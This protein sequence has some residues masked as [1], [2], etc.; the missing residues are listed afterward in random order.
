MTP[1]PKLLT[2]QE[3]AVLNQRSDAKGW[4]Q[5][6]GHLALLAVSGGLWL[7]G[8][9]GW[10]VRLP[11]L[12]TY[13][14]GLAAM[15]AAVHECVHRTA[16]ASNRAND[17][18][19]WI[20]GLLSFYNSSFYRRYHKWHHRFTQIPGKDP[21]LADPK[22]QTWP[23]YLLELSGLPWWLGKIRTHFKVATGQFADYPYIPAE[24]QSEVQRSLLWQLAV[25]GALIALSLGLKQ[26]LFVT[27]WLL[28]LAVGQPILRAIL[29]A[30][31]SGCSEDDNPLTNTR[32]TLTWAPLRWLMWNMPFHAE[33][34][35]CASI[36]FH[37]LPSAHEKLSSYWG[38]LDRGY[39]AV[40]KALILTFGQA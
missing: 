8:W 5:F 14:F 39:L 29:L 12:V 2:A 20:A 19:A 17:T 40:N 38:H 3:L 36:P 21:E 10:A 30:E 22:P 7:S 28:P 32:T 25:Y 16:F 15:F 37:A 23:Q 4:Q 13:G 27:A 24:A 31:H 6:F 11:A 9:S 34:H 33:H 35:F 26:P 18:V 1:A